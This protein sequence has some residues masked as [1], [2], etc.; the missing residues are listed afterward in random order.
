MASQEASR[1]LQRLPD[2]ILLR[3]FTYLEP[4]DFPSLQLGCQTL[5]RRRRMARVLDGDVL[6]EPLLDVAVSLNQEIDAAEPKVQ[7]VH[8]TSIARKERRFREIANWDPTFPGESV[9]WYDEYIQ[10]NAP[11]T[12]SWLQQPCIRDGSFEDLLDVRGVALYNP[13]GDPGNMLAVSPLDDG[14]IC[15]WDVKGRRG[16]KGAIVAKSAPGIIHIDGPGAVGRS[17]KIDAGVTECISVDSQGKRAFVAVQGHL[18]EVDLERL[19]VVSDQS[20][21][22]SIAALSSAHVDAPLTVG[23]SLG[24]HLYD[25]RARHH[26]PHDAIDQIF[27]TDPLP[28]Y[29]PLSQ[30]HPLSI[31]HLP[32]SSD[33]TIL[34][35]DIYVAGRFSNILHYD[36]RKLAPIVGS[37]HSGARLASLAS[38][39]HSFSPLDTE[40]R[41]SGELSVDQVR[42]SKEKPGRTLIAGGE[43]NTKGSLELYALPN[44][45]RAQSGRQHNSN[46]KNRY[47]ASQSKILSVITHGTCIVFSDGSGYIK[48]FERDGFTEVRRMRIGQS[49]PINRP[50]LFS[51]MPGID[52]LARKILSTQTPGH[53][54]RINDG[55]ILFW[56]G[57][58]L[59]LVSLSKTPR[60]KPDDF[61]DREPKTEEEMHLE[62]QEAE[63]SE[64]M[65]TALER[66]ADD[67][68]LVR[69]LG[70]GA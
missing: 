52:D 36:R 59:G 33:G 15:L 60:F 25:Y 31:L 18:K 39:P 22:W 2:E 37:I 12:T 38:L 44:S 35:D 40:V 46:F 42:E 24:I 6:N 20:F 34:S 55:E 58:K 14:S 5:E 41:R 23:T 50:S 19:A 56:T 57:E 3:I 68:R 64:R 53:S 67:V 32:I 29:A 17:R 16:R 66:Q 8:G 62:Q 63:Y 30:P 9:C 13:P 10:R 48:W 65:R 1:T 51:Q 28:Q 69:D 54:E 21:E 49:E 61:S 7:A 47:D 26:R 43:Y 45:D 11:V 70:L 4:Q 27:D